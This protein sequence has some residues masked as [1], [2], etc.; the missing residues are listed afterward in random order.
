MA[1]LVAFKGNVCHDLATDFLALAEK[2]GTTVPRMIGHRIMGA[3]LVHTGHF[4]ESRTHLDRAFALYNPVEHRPLATRFSLEAEIAILSYRSQALWLLGYPDAALRDANDARENARQTSQAAALMIALN[5][6]SPIYCGNYVA[7]S[8]QA[9]ELIA[10]ADKKG[11]LF[12]KA[13]GMMQRGVVLALTGKASNAI[14]TITAAIAARRS[15][16]STLGLPW[17]LS[18]LARAYAELDHWDDARRC[19][20]EALTAAETT[21]ERCFE[22]D[23]HRTAGEIILLSP[24]PDTTKAETYFD[25]ALAVARQQQAKSLELRAATSLARLW[26]DQGKVQQA[27]ELLA[28]VYGWFTEGFDT[29]DLNEAKALLE[30]LGT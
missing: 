4:V 26:R 2:Q 23:I 8:A 27:R 20:G 25:R 5:I 3:T 11:A 21:K 7:A 12:W 29:R 17:Q 13:A 15:S 30:E 19:I 10:L 18:C 24:D 16:G 6:T 9:D 14:Q 22:A 28:P 1:N